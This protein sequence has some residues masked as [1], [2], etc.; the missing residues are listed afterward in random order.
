MDYLLYICYTLCEKAQMGLIILLLKKSCSVHLG[1]HLGV[2]RSFGTVVSSCALLWWSVRVILYW[3]PWINTVHMKLGSS[4]PGLCRTAWT[5]QSI[6]VGR[7][8]KK[9]K[10]NFLSCITIP[11][12]N[13]SLLLSL[14]YKMDIYLFIQIRSHITTVHHHI[15]FHAFLS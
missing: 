4:H 2:A 13:F 9:G 5:R 11:K 7:R 6:S 12:S 14:W 1:R 10:F 8:G 3:R 15:T